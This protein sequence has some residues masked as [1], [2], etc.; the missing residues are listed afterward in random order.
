ML[1]GDALRS[2]VFSILIGVLCAVNSLVVSGI[3]FFWVNAASQQSMI[4]RSV[5]AH[6]PSLPQGSVVLLDGFCKYSGP[7][8]VFE[9]PWDASGAMQITLNNDSL[10][11]TVV[12]PNLTFK[13]ASFAVTEYG[14]EQDIPYS[15]HL[16]VYNLR[17][18]SLT[19]L[20]SQAAAIA[21][22]KQMNPTGNGGCPAA[23]EGKG[24][25][26]F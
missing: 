21:Y 22:L 11:S 26:I 7:A 8:V 2:R 10:Y 20:P 13:D 15:D 16:F 24:A 5:A 19:K 4:L 14:T 9:A 23:Q 25:A 12:S 1:K 6:I 3:G 17:N 18:A